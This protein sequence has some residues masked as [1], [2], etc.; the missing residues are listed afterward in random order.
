MDGE[1]VQRGIAGCLAGGLGN[2]GA[3]CGAVTGA[4]MAIGL[5]R[6]KS[7]SMETMMANLATAA[8]FRRRFE[9]EVGTIDCR[10]LT[11]LDLTTPE[12]LQKLMSS[13]IPQTACFPAVARAYEIAVAL[14]REAP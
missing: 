2:T 9:A 1:I 13:D 6:G 8:E 4:L 3:V 7:D 12:G 14:L 11:G 10:E 5:Y